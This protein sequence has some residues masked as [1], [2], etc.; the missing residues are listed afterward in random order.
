ME[1]NPDVLIIGGGL[2][3]L[4]AAIHLSQKHLKVILI[5]KSAYPKHKVCGE[6]ISNE[7]LPYLQWLGADVSTLNPT[8]I[9]KFAFTTN[10]GK[11][12]TAKLPLG[13]FGIS[14]YEL[15]NFLYQKTLANNCTI[16]K[17]TVTDVSFSNE[18]FT[19]TTSNQILTAK[20]VLGAF[21]KRSNVDQV[22]DRNFIN[23]KSP[24]LAVKAHYSGTLD[25]D[26]VALHNFKGGYCGVSKVENNIIN[27]CYL[28]DYA[29]FKQYKNIEDYQQNVLYKNKHLKAVFEN[30]TL[31]FDKPLT[32]SQ[33]SFDKK[34]AVEN[35]IL[36]IG[37]TAGLIHPLCGNGMAMA[38]HSAKIASELILNYY[39][40]KEISRALLEKTYT[41]EWN[42]HFGKRIFMGQILARILTHKTITNIL[43]AIVAS[44]PG[45]LPGIIKQ[46]HGKPIAIH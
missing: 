6:Y 26:L 5:E 22:L 25:N 38:I 32:I 27:I 4:A 46:T 28:A 39:S 19:V 10:N 33:I 29:T 42:K 12:A 21:G 1:T 7:I 36:M 9:S 40:D 37:D 8:N 44:F 41:K 24:W 17:E 14:R 34:E 13:G 45:L 35:H 3:G 16:I 31:L 30:S 20:I 2:A 23:K 18:L 11:A 15:D 43:V